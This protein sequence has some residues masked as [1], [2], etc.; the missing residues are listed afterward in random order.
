MPT[1]GAI[2]AVERVTSSRVD[3][4]DL[5]CRST[6]VRLL[7]GVFGYIE[8]AGEE[9]CQIPCRLPFTW[10]RHVDH[11]LAIISGRSCQRQT[12]TQLNAVLE[13]FRFTEKEANPSGCQMPAFLGIQKANKERRLL[14]VLL[15][16]QK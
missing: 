9:Y 11:I 16:L 5:R 12:L 8:F 13:K 1:D 3:S 15:R 7:C 6:T 2:Q 10:L 14:S 4:I